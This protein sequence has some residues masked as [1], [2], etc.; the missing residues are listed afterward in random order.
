M[1]KLQLQLR[2]LQPSYATNPDNL[3]PRKPRVLQSPE[4]EEVQ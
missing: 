1:V 2:S 4:V 3:Q